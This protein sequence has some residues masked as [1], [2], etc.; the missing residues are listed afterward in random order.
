MKGADL[1]RSGTC[2]CSFLLNT[3]VNWPLNSSAFSRSDW[4]TPFPFFLCIYLALW[5]RRE[6]KLV[7]LRPPNNC[8]R[9]STIS[10]IVEYNDYAFAASTFLLVWLALSQ[11]QWT[12]KHAFFYNNNKNKKKKKQKKSTFYFMSLR[13]SLICWLVIKDAYLSGLFISRQTNTNNIKA[14]KQQTLNIA[15]SSNED[16]DHPGHPHSPNSDFAVRILAYIGWLPIERTTKTNQTVCMR[17][18]IWAFAACTCYFV[19][20]L[21]ST[22]QLVPNRFLTNLR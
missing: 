13:V 11:H 10:G 1:S 18:Q 3:S 7:V 8:R 16:S 12:Y 4:A 19:N 17:V 20:L 9:W 5:Q 14:V 2:V 6:T 21:C 15:S 22:H